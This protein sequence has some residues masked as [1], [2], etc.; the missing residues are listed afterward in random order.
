LVAELERL[1][2]PCQFLREK[3]V[4]TSVA[5]ERELYQPPVLAGVDGA[6]SLLWGKET[7]RFARQA[8]TRE[9]WCR[10]LG[11]L[12]ALEAVKAALTAENRPGGWE[13][14]EL[15]ALLMYLEKRGAEPDEELRELVDGSKRG[16]LEQARKAILLPERVR[17]MVLQG[18]VTLRHGEELAQLPD[19]LMD[20]VAGAL[21][22]GSFS[23]RRELLQMSVELYKRYRE[24]DPEIEDR[25]LEALGGKDPRETLYALRYPSYSSARD[26][27]TV[28][29]DRFLKGTG[30]RLEEP[31]NLEGDSFSL[32]IPFS[33][34]EELEKRL[35]VAERASREIEA[36]TEL[37]G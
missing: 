2:Q 37:L 13:L 35:E 27:L 25:L 18:S 19:A 28:F 26:T 4:P 16:T 11:A 3:T 31:P 22:E 34:R 21:G 14:A 17:E 36:V 30:V 5:M 6:P 9:L 1:P 20:A 10:E 23:T 29:R 12:D 15:V 32:V 24:E 33:T 8:G 7:L